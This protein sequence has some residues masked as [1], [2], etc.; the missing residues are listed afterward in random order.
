MQILACFVMP[1]VVRKPV[2]IPQVQ[3]LACF[4]MP[5]VVRKP[6]ETPQVQILDEVMVITTGGGPDSANRLEVPKLQVIFKGRRLSYCGAEADP[7]GPGE[8]PQLPC[9]VVDVPVGQMQQLV[10]CPFMQRQVSWGPSVQRQSRE[11]SWCET[12]QKTRSSLQFLSKVVD[13]PVVLDDRR[14][15]LSVQELWSS[16]C[17]D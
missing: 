12:V 7:P 11:S 3:F 15:M 9:T 17:A 10:R 5:V 16:C 14:M 13:V 8:I 2:E 4:V 6:V 1:V